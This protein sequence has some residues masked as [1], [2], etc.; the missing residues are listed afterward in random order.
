MLQNLQDP[1]GLSKTREIS[2]QLKSTKFCILN[3][4]LYWKDP[5]G[6]LL[7]FLLENGAKNPMKEFH[8]GDC[9]GH[10]SWKVTVNKILR[11]GFY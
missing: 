7:N 6:G 3:E 8:K 2:I 11:V 5:G 10:Y 4:Y 9:G 1:A